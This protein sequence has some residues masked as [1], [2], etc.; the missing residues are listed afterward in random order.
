VGDSVNSRIRV[1]SRT[2][3]WEAWNFGEGREGSQTDPALVPAATQVELET[4]RIQVRRLIFLGHMGPEG[5][6]VQSWPAEDKVFRSK[7][8]LLLVGRQNSKPTRLRRMAP[9]SAWNPAPHRRHSGQSLAPPSQS[10]QAAPVPAGAGERPTT[11]H[12]M[13]TEVPPTVS[14]LY[15][16]PCLQYLIRA[17]ECPVFHPHPLRR[18]WGLVKILVIKLTP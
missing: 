14:P 11:D 12:H 8:E 5:Q 6:L 10:P 4:H 9:R 17:A 18:T 1:G 2:Q 16:G 13:G 15:P 7:Q 3:F